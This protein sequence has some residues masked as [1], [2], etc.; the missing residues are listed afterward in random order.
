MQECVSKHP[1]LQKFPALKNGI[2]GEMQ[3]RLQTE[4]PEILMIQSLDQQLVPMI[5]FLKPGVYL[6]ITLG[7]LEQ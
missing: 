4:L 5:F 6:R 7:K 3:K 2:A 1:A